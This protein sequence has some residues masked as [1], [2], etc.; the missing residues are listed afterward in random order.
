MKRTPKELDARIGEMVERCR[1]E[2]MNLTPQRLVIFRALL[3]SEDHPSPELLRDRVRDQL[4][5]V[6]LATIYKTLDVLVTLGFAAE[7]PV[8]GNTKRYDGNMGAHHHL[9]CTRCGSVADADHASLPEIPLP[10]SLHGFAPHGYSVHV[11]G[12]CSTCRSTLTTPKE[13]KSWPKN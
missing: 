4:P 6:S 12:L 10:R 13:K 1:S 11:H 8:T 9:V 5:A 2:G 7:V 3:E